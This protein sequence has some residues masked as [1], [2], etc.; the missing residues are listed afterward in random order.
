MEDLRKWITLESSPSM[1]VFA[2]TNGAGKSQLTSI[3]QHQNPNVK[4]IDADAIAKTMK[5][6]PVN[7][8]NFAAGR[9]AVK[10]VRYCIKQGVDFSIETTLGGQNVLRQMEMAKAAGFSINMYYVGL[11]SVE[12]HID[13]VAQRVAQGGHHI[14]EEDIRR[15]Y[16]TSMEN[17]PNAMSLADR[18]IIYDNSEVYQVQAEVYLCLTQFQRESMQ[19]WANQALKNWTQT[20]EKV[21]KELQQ[22]K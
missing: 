2:G 15:R 20:Q 10:Q 19:P 21:K 16:Q 22:E 9:E 3:L 14:P 4:V 8:A 12:L 13:R 5:H 6:L 17:L 7:Q 18:T 11:N 1:T